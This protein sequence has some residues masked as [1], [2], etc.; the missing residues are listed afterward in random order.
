MPFDSAGV[1]AGAMGIQVTLPQFNPGNIPCK[2][3]WT[4]KLTG[5]N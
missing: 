5:V 2:D 1:R 3:A 4:I